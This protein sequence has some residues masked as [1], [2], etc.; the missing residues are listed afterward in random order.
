MGHHS[1][2]LFFIA[3]VDGIKD[4]FFFFFLKIGKSLPFFYWWDIQCQKKKKMQRNPI[5]NRETIKKENNTL[6]VFIQR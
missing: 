3:V 2:M 1:T 5:W 4:S 6:Q